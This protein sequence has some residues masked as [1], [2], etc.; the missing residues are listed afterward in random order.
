MKLKVSQVLPMRSPNPYR[1]ACQGMPPC[2]GRRRAEKDADI[3]DEGYETGAYKVRAGDRRYLCP[4]DRWPNR[5]VWGL[6][7]MAAQLDLRPGWRST[8]R[9]LIVDPETRRQ[10]VGRD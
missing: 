5:V 1:E 4:W 3:W 2:R 8:F 7:C 6:G 9:R 10:T